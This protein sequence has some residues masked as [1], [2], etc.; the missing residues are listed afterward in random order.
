MPGKAKKS[1]ALKICSLALF[2]R[3]T[4]LVADT[5]QFDNSSWM[6]SMTIDTF[7][8]QIWPHVSLEGLDYSLNSNRLS[9]IICR[10]REG[11][12]SQKVTTQTKPILPSTGYMTGGFSQEECI[13]VKSYH[14]YLEKWSHNTG[15]LSFEGSQNAGMSV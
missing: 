9:K 8:D 1:I 13:N 2:V 7:H 15:S 10:E 4:E 11:N 5:L 6:H 3:Q 12:S 14:W